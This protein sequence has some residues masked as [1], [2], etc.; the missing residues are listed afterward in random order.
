MAIILPE[1]EQ[2]IQNRIRTD[3]Q[4]ELPKSNPFFRNSYLSGLMVGIAGRFFDLTIQ[5][6]EL[7]KQ[8]FPD[9]A[10]GEFLE[11]WANYF[12]LSRNLATTASGNIFITGSILGTIVPINTELQSSNSISYLTQSEVTIN[13]TILS[14]TL[15]RVGTTVTAV[16]ASNHNLGNGLEVTI[17]G[18]TEA[19]YNGTFPITVTS[20]TEFTYEIVGAPTTPATGAPILT[21]LGTSVNIVSQTTGSITNLVNGDNLTFTN[22]IAG[23]DSQATVDFAEIAGG[24]DQELDSSLSSRT[25]FRVQNP[26]SL[27]NVA[28]ITNAALS[29]TGV[30]RVW[31]E[32]IT[33]A[34]G[35]VTIR[36][37]RDNDSDIIPTAP[38]IAA[39]KTSILEI[40]PAHVDEADVIVE[41]PTPIDVDFTF[42]LLSP[43]TTAMKE[44]ITAN[45]EALFED[46]TQV[47][48]DLLD[49]LYESV[50]YNTI[51]STG[52]RLVDFTLSTPTGTVAIANG[53]LAVLGSIT[54]P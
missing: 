31:V 32:E 51:D 8:I 5:F 36:F 44:A 42:T 53:E 29:V 1:N 25:T 50:I 19:E 27:F 10:T 38:E 14:L 34:V 35:Q 24:S 15:S 22:L 4:N 39:V 37:T 20:A 17:S 13:N 23:V 11:R 41:A 6:L 43:N 45:L 33:P 18:A 26:V 46:Q 40:K 30:T 3:V 47:S 12:G 16:T 7:I 52:T 2:E 28:A 48:Q 9:T 49:H 54:Y 21:I